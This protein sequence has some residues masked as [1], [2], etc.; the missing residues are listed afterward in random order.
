MSENIASVFRRPYVEQAKK[1]KHVQD[2]KDQAVFFHFFARA[3]E[4]FIARMTPTGT[5]D[6][7]MFRRMPEY[8]FNNGE[9][10]VFERDGDLHAWLCAGIG[11]VDEYGYSQQYI[12][13]SANGLNQQGEPILTEPKTDKDKKNRVLLDPGDMVLFRPNRLCVPIWTILEPIIYR[14]SRTIRAIDN[15]TGKRGI[16][17]FSCA[18]ATAKAMIDDITKAIENGDSVKCI[19]APDA[20]TAQ[21]RVLDLFKDAGVPLSDLW[22]TFRQYETFLC[23]TN[24]ENVVSFEKKERLIVSE[25]EANNERIAN[26]IFGVCREEME[27]GLALVNEKWKKDWK[28]PEPP[29]DPEPDPDPDQNKEPDTDPDPNTKEGD[30]E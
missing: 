6:P 2:L 28:L 1:L 4:S 17:L 15:V 9:F 26:G 5:G 25:V 23:E 29:K 19:T 13:Y 3:Y 24:G 10:A 30:D 21:A 7:R 8:F 20:G 16:S 27:R 14:M 18:D 11:P 22:E 12:A